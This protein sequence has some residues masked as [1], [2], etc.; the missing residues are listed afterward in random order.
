MK[1]ISIVLATYNG[2][3]YVAAQLDSI[4]CQ[5]VMP[6]EIIIV[7]DCSKDDTW[8]LLNSYNFLK[9]EVVLLKNPE[10]L[11][12]IETF[13]RGIS[14]ATG[15]FVALCD[16]DDIWL[17]NKLQ[18]QLESFEMLDSEQLIKPIVV[19]SDLQLMG[20]DG[21]DLNRTF[22]KAH[23]MQ[24]LKTDFSKSLVFNE[25]VGCSMLLNRSMVSLIEK[26]PSEILM[27][28]HWI[29]MIGKSFGLCLVV[30][31]PL[32]RYRSHE[33]SVTAKIKPSLVN[34]IFNTIGNLFSKDYLERNIKQAILFRTQYEVNLTKEQREILDRLIS[35]KR[36]SYILKK[37][38]TSIICK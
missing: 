37:I 4:L 36:K 8:E 13:K 11:G 33:E 34:R 2:A 15:D 32:I 16:Q 23:N 3:K 24:P 35:L 14:Y 21:K 29:Y 12:V 17:S 22:W 28:D 10:N 38:K 25:A 7:D 9:T 6:H 1:K 18:I 20:S 26:M 19:L 27:H 5:T 31:V 30:D